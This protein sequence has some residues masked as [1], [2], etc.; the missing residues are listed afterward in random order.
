MLAVQ[1]PDEHRPDLPPEDVGLELLQAG[2]SRWSP[3]PLSRYHWTWAASSPLPSN[4]RMISRS[5]RMA[6]EELVLSYKLLSNVE[7]AFRCLKSVDLMVRPIRHRLENRV[8]AHIFLCMLAYYVQWHMMEAWRP[9]LFAD[10]DQESK[11]TRDP[12]AAAERS[13]G[14]M[15]KVHGKR[16]D[17]DSL[18]HSFRTL[19]DELSRIVSNVCRCPHLGPDAPTFNKTTAPNPKQQEAL[20]LLQAI[21]L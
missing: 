18:V 12:V 17:D 16:L 10:E 8:R 2:R 13:Q 3:P 14:A 21:S 15:Q 7:Y 4:H 19:L 1:S 5:Q 20:R 6:T 11:A 9:L